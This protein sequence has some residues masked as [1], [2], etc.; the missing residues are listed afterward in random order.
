MRCTAPL[1]GVLIFRKCTKQH[2]W[3]KVPETER[4]K[5]EVE[6]QRYEL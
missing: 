2:Q 5:S 3:E 4:V 1:L 6:D